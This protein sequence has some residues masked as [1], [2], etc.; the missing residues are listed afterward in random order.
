[1]ELIYEDG[2]KPTQYTLDTLQAIRK[3]L[4]NPEQGNHEDMLVFWIFVAKHLNVLLNRAYLISGEIPVAKDL[5][6]FQSS[7]ESDFLENSGRRMI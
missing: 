5:N 4:G 2:V 6:V 7:W 3:A 1:M